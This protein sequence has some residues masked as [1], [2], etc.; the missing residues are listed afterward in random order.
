MVPDSRQ[1]RRLPPALLSCAQ[2][3]PRA[4]P[5]A[6]SPG[7]NS[8]GFGE[9][10]PHS[11]TPA[12]LPVGRPEDKCL[13]N[14]QL[15]LSP[16]RDGSDAG[17]SEGGFKLSPWHVPIPVAGCPQG[18]LSSRPCSGCRCP[19]RVTWSHGRQHGAVSAPAGVPVS[20]V[21]SIFTQTYE[22]N[23]RLFF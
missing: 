21:G 4:Q 11:Y 7:G 15:C 6:A 16:F 8:P 17:G 12:G 13:E 20:P 23:K 14:I 3:L 18:G 9:P 2:S 1:E 5:Q 10:A 19:L 22:F